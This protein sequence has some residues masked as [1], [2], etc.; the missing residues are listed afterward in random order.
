MKI[1]MIFFV[2]I[3]VLTGCIVEKYSANGCPKAKYGKRHD[4]NLR[5]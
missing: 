2:V 1:L 3:S 4:K 5:F